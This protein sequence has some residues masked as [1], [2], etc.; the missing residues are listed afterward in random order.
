[1]STKTTFK[2]IALVAVAALGLGVVSSVAPANAAAKTMTVE[3][4]SMTVVG[5]YATTNNSTKGAVAYKILVKND[6]TTSVAANLGNSE[7]ITATVISAPAAANGV[8][9]NVTDLGFI[10]VKNATTLA[11]DT[12]TA[13]RIDNTTNNCT[14]PV[15]A[16]ATYDAR[17]QYCIGILP[18]LNV[19]GYGEY[20]I[21]FDLQ[22][23]NG[24]V[25]QRSIVKYKM[26]TAA[27]SGA[28][29]TIASA[30]GLVAGE[31]YAQSTT[32][33]MTASLADANGG[34]IVVN[35]TTVA[36]RRPALSAT[37]EN[38]TG[39][40]LNTLTAADDGGTTADASDADAVASD[41]NYGL[42]P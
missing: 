30:G 27:N 13:G 35:D 5:T 31:T 26:T 19:T 15:A 10:A 41:G 38:A 29:V 12:S 32:K 2:R 6:A 37:L 36:T 8:T 21:A 24:N 11:A 17:G 22:D 1:M 20:Q 39:T 4:S 33:Y 42:I 16:S 18:A 25:L 34:K 9:P 40:V 14:Y 3:T 28:V 23:A 7:T